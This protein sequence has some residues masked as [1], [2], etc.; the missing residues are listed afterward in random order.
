MQEFVFNAVLEQPDRPN[1]ITHD[2]IAKANQCLDAIIE[3]KSDEQQLSVDEAKHKIKSFLN[4]FRS[5]TIQVADEQAIID[6][7]KTTSNVTVY[8]SNQNHVALTGLIVCIDLTYFTSPEQLAQVSNRSRSHQLSNYLK[9]VQQLSKQQ[10]LNVICVLKSSNDI[11][12][13]LLQQQNLIQT[14]IHIRP[15][16]NFIDVV[17]PLAFEFGFNSILN[18]VSELSEEVIEYQTVSENC[19][20]YIPVLPCDINTEDVNRVLIKNQE[21]EMFDYAHYFNKVNFKLNYFCKTQFQQEF[22]A[23]INNLK[24]QKQLFPFWRFATKLWCHRVW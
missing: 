15:E 21:E 7:I 2:F 4:Q 19:F 24:R 1:V 10:K 5:K 6:L 3:R 16:T 12:N 9:F 8:Y 14:L 17:L 23:K 13:Q 11:Y 20:V 18:F 22:Q